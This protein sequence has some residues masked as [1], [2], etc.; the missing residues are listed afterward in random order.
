M[1]VSRCKQVPPAF[2]RC[3][4]LR[5]R[6]LSACFLFS[7]SLLF[8]LLRGMKI[9]WGKGGR[10]VVRRCGGVGWSIGREAADIAS[11]IG[12]AAWQSVWSTNF[13]EQY[14]KQSVSKIRHIFSVFF[15]IFFRGLKN[16]YSWNILRA[17][18]NLSCI[19]FSYR[20]RL[21]ESSN[22]PPPVKIVFFFFGE[23]DARM[24]CGGG[25]GGGGGK[26][27]W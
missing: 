7:L 18:N 3:E 10:I 9:R 25:G 22:P 17:E 6:S 24:N 12:K 2:G 20:P 8:P 21:L 13:N 5:M 16:H 14:H 19:F 27:E 23:K 15:R 4:R 1:C 11:N 26:R